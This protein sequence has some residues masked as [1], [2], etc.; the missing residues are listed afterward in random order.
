MHLGYTGLALNYAIFA[1]SIIFSCV[2]SGAAQS[3]RYDS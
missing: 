3:G 2:I 1:H